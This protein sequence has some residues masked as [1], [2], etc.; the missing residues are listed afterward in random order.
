MDNKKYYTANTYFAMHPEYADL[1][2]NATKEDLYG[3]NRYGTDFYQIK[4][5]NSCITF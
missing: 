4:M 5:D 2:E 3:A 1:M